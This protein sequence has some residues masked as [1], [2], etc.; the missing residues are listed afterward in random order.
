MKKEEIYPWCKESAFAGKDYLFIKRE[1]DQLDFSEEEKIQILIKADEYIA[2]YQ[3]A[4]QERDKALQQMLIGLILLIMGAGINLYS[5]FTVGKHYLL[6]DG[7]TLIGFFI[8]REAYIT[9]QI[10]LEEFENPLDKV[11]RKIQ[12]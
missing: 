1:V 3:V 12:R 7:L 9:Y 8:F 2:H 10:P 5:Y 11:T 6:L 4:L